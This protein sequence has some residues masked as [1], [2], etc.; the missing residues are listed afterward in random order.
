MSRPRVLVVPITLDPP[1]G[2]S[3]VGAW[4]IQGLREDCCVSVLTWRPVDLETVNEAFGTRLLSGDAAWF[5]VPHAWRA[6]LDYSPVPLSLM[7]IA[8]T[9][10]YAR[11]LV[12]K[13]RFDAILGTMNEIDVGRPAIQYVHYPW[14]SLPRPEVDMRWYHVE[15]ALRLYRQVARRVA[16]F[17]DSSACRNVTFTNSEWT[18][19]AFRRTYRAPCRVLYPPVPGGFTDTPLADR[20]RS[21]IVLGRI[22]RE[23]SLEKIIDILA[24]VRARGHEIGLTFAG[25]VDDPGYGRKIYDL[26]ANHGDWIQFRHDLSRSEL[27]ALLTRYRYAIH[28]MLG[29]H[30][31]IAPAELQ[32]AGC[33][34]FVPD[35]GGPVEIVDHDSRVIYSDVEDAVAKICNVLKDPTLERGLFE[36]VAARASRFSEFHFMNGIRHAVMKLVE[37][38]P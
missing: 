18:A 23:K 27:V 34:T 28:G 8:L 16:G 1:G 11:A 20:Q 12:E 26:A 17:S 15:W 9:M 6:V 36:A 38:P 19:Q 35:D 30:F 21:F 22:A 4:A 3:A 7:R 32:R 25:H 10:R 33:I 14:A 24:R 31:G 13:G 37:A 5:E 29:E 2:G